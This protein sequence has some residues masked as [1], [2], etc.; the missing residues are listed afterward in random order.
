[1]STTDQMLE[2]QKQTGEL[3]RAE[4]VNSSVG[5]GRC[6]VFSAVCGRL[7]AARVT[8]EQGTADTLMLPGQGSL[9]GYADVTGG[10]EEPQ[11]LSFTTP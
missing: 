8:G 2:N 10:R 5:G 9:H 3:N 1:M 6:G 7:W 4:K 11:H